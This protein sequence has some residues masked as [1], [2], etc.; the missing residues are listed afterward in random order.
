MTEGTL[1]ALRHGLACD[2][3]C[4]PALK[5]GKKVPGMLIAPDPIHDDAIV[6]PTGCLR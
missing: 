6:L 1:D 2:P 5:T 3:A 4:T